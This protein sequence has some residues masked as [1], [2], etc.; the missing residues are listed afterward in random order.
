MM[1]SADR[2]RFRHSIQASDAGSNFPKKNRGRGDERRE[3]GGHVRAGERPAL[4]DASEGRRKDE[5]FARP[6]DCRLA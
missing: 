3:D 1:G 4:F 6:R 5:L 2:L